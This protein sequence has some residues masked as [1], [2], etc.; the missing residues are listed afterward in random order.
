MESKR[1]RSLMIESRSCTPY[2]AVGDCSLLHSSHVL[3]RLSKYL[4]RST[5][6]ALGI[7]ILRGL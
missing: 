4:V 2:L 3:S 6:S 1:P 7:S 5:F